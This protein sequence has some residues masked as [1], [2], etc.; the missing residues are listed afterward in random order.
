MT[1]DIRHQG[2]TFCE[3]T[4]G[5]R[6]RSSSARAE[7]GQGHEHLTDTASATFKNAWAACEMLADLPCR[8]DAV[9]DAN[10]TRE[11]ECEPIL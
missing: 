4:D 7:S 11:P 9:S 10:A 1:L 8:P 3:T 5:D 6:F 2:K